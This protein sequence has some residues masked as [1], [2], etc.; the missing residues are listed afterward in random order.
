MELVRKEICAY[1]FRPLNGAEA[2]L[3]GFTGDW[4]DTNGYFA[5]EKSMKGNLSMGDSAEAD[6]FPWC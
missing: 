4:N 2:Y 5:E 6:W 3:S 1:V